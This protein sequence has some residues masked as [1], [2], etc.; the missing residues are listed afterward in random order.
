M[1]YYQSNRDGNCFPQTING[2]KM[3]IGLDLCQT[4]HCVMVQ[5]NFK[6]KKIAEKNKFWNF[7]VPPEIV[8]DFNPV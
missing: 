8:W 1:V 3:L 6:K 2:L 5:I 4:D 7:F